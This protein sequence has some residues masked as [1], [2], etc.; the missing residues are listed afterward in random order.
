[1]NR[2]ARV[3]EALFRAYYRGACGSFETASKE[4]RVYFAAT[5]AKTLAEDLDPTFAPVAN[6]IDQVRRE[7]A[8]RWSRKPRDGRERELDAEEDAVH[9]LA[10]ITT[11]EAS[12]LIADVLGEAIATRHL[13]ALGREVAERAL[14]AFERACSDV[15]SVAASGRIYGGD[16]AAA[17]GK[18]DGI[19]EIALPEGLHSIMIRIDGDPDRASVSLILG[20]ARKGSKIPIPIVVI[21]EGATVGIELPSSGLETYPSPHGLSPRE[22]IKVEGAC[23]KLRIVAGAF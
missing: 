6:G 4:D 3:A 14:Q 10:V 13:S 9:L 19:G 22:V 17:Q 16:V 2:V 5:A 1:V 7:T 23:A 20:A 21:R 12:T 8:A 18:H 11:P 15:D